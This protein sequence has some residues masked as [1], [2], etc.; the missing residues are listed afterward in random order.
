[1]ETAALQRFVREQK[2]MLSYT[3]KGFVPQTSGPHWGLDR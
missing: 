1:M 2:F 3:Q